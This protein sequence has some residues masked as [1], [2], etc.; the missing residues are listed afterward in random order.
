MILRIFH[1]SATNAGDDSSLPERNIRIATDRSRR[2]AIVTLTK[3]SLPVAATLLLSVVAFWPEVFSHQK[4]SSSAMESSVDVRSASGSLR[5]ARYHGI[6]HQGHPYTVTAA[7]VRQ[8]VPANLRLSS[9]RGEIAL[10]NGQWMLASAENGI[11][12]R[13]AEQLEL[14]QDVTV[15]RDDG[16]TLLTDNLAIDLRTN[17]V[18]GADAVHIEGAFGLID[19]RGVTIS[20]NGVA[21]DFGGPAR[22]RLRGGRR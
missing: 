1:R 19:A 3:W 13:P 15:Y 6:D 8:L 20:E 17:S 16:T 21:V 12:Y 9:P 18:A 11:Y 2:R 10:G 5:M 7:S 14:S 22:L 4:K